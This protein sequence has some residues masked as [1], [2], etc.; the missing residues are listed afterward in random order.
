MHNARTSKRG[1][2]RATRTS[3]TRV[4]ET[5]GFVTER[6]SGSDGLRDG[7][8][9][10][11]GPYAVGLVVHAEQPSGEGTDEHQ[12][13]AEN[14]DRADGEHDVVI[15]GIDERGYGDD[16]AVAADG[17]AGADEQRSLR[18]VSFNIRPKTMADAMAERH[19]GD[20]DREGPPADGGG[21]G[22]A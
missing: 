1:A 4:A 17:G 15:L 20:D 14:I 7:V 9:R 18:D 10:G 6:E 8:D 12:D 13:E 16:R 11:S 19:G 22:D 3:F 21:V 2:S 5:A